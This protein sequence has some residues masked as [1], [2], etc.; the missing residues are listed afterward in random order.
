MPNPVARHANFAFEL[1]RSGHVTFSVYDVTGRRVVRLVNAT[2]ACGRALGHVDGVSDS[3]RAP[4]ER[5]VYMY[6]VAMGAD[7]VV[8]PHDPGPLA[9]SPHA[10][11]PGASSP[12]HPASGEVV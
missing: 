2:A 6:E 10:R 8:A 9:R 11:W 7:P 5:R 3:G 4:R 1:Y 12:G